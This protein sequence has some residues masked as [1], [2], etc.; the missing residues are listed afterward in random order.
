M[1]EKYHLDLLSI[2]HKLFY[3]FQY[4]FISSETYSKPDIYGSSSTRVNRKAIECCDEWHICLIVNPCDLERGRVI[5]GP[6]S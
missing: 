1:C 2:D 5:S 4:N 3:G 6:Y